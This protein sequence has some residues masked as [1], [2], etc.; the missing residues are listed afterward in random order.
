LHNRLIFS[1]TSRNVQTTSRCIALCLIVLAA[2]MAVS[3][4]P[5]HAQASS[6]LSRL[7]ISLDGGGLITRASNGTNP[8]PSAVNY[9]VAQSATTTTAGQVTVRYNKSM[10]LGAEYNFS[11][12]RMTESYVLTP[13]LTAPNP[14][15]I[16][17]SWQE[18]SVG[19]VIHGP[20]IMGM[21][22]FAS[23]GIGT[24][25]FKPTGAGG[26]SF[27]QQNRMEEYATAGLDDPIFTR[28]C[29]IRVQIR[30]IFYKAPDF[31]TNY[32]TTNS[33]TSTVEPTLGF[34]LRF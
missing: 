25:K 7:E 14:F 24:L 18:N 10:L 20:Y 13:P 27:Q 5:A 1:Q 32:L 30:D 11:M 8:P 15:T 4:V 19:Y 2:L 6:Q 26:L 12:S 17:T 29:G 34:Y 22:P 31:G 9:Q 33:H 28:K 23:A 21:Q 16:Q 3:C